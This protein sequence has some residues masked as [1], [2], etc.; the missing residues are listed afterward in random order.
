MSVRDFGW[1]T[2]FLRNRY[3]LVVSIVVAL[4]AGIFGVQS[5]QRFED[6]R[7]VN[8]YPIIITPFPG[9]SAERVE[10]LVTEKLEDELAEVSAIKNMTSTSLSGVSIVVIELLESVDKFTYQ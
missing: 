5:L 2:L 9:A 8:R 7:I 4:A 3:L 10:T 1:Q 6:P